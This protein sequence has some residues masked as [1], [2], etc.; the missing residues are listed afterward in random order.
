MPPWSSLVS[1]RAIARGP[2]STGGVGEVFPRASALG[3][4]A[5]GLGDDPEGLVPA[6]EAL[7]AR[8]LLLQVL[9]DG[10]EVLDLG[11]QRGLDVLQPLDVRPHRV[12]EGDA[13]DLVVLAL[14]VPHPEQPD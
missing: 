9:V 12:P 14:L 1:V 10:E 8:L 5:P 7:R 3:R 2:V 13:D 6:G 11:P 4:A